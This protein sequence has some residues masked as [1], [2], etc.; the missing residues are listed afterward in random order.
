[1]IHYPQNSTQAAIRLLALGTTVDGVA[2][3]SEYETLERSGILRRLG[4]SRE[5]FDDALD[6]LCKDL[7]KSCRENDHGFVHV[8]PALVEAILDEI[9]D[10]GMQR[11][12]ASYLL[13]IIGADQRVTRAESYL[14]WEVLDHWG[15]KF[16]DV[17]GTSVAWSGGNAASAYAAIPASHRYS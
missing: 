1:M 16:R 2:F 3:E 9:R 15:L 17:V 5:Q 6:S 8:R 4:I 7:R 14:F 12:L 11:V 13:D 10:P